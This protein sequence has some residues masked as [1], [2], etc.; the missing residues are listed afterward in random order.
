M[1][2]LTLDYSFLGCPSLGQV[3]AP[4]DETCALFQGVPPIRGKMIPRQGETTPA[5]ETKEDLN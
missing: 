5:Q 2:S 3:T 4:K 1:G